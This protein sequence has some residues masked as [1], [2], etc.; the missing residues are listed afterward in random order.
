[1]INALQ[2]VII[3][4]VLWAICYMFGS[5]LD[6]KSE[7]NTGE[8]IVVGLIIIMALFQAVALPFMYYETS[9]SPLYMICIGFC[10]AVIVAYIVLFVKNKEWCNI[11]RKLLVLCHSASKK[12]IL[13]WGGLIALILFQVFYVIY[14]QHADE[15]DSYYIAQINTVLETNRLM[16]IEPTTGIDSFKQ[17]AT[18]KLIGHE[19]LLSL[20]A[21]FFHANA[22]FLCHMVMPIVMIPIHY[23]IVYELAKVIK[24]K[25][26]EIFFLLCLFVNAFSAFSG[27]TSSAFLF[28]RI[29]QGKAVLV[30]ILLPFMMLEFL[31]IY[32]ERNVSYKKLM[33]LIAVLWAGFFTTTVGLYLIPI[34]YFVYTA[35]YFFSFKDF[36]N[37]FKLCI[38]VLLSLPFVFVKFTTFLSQ[39]YFNGMDTYEV[40]VTYGSALFEKLLYND[41]G[42]IWVIFFVFSNIYIWK[43]GTQIE[44]MIST[45]ASIILFLTFANPLLM[46]IVVKYV[47]GESVYWR[48]FW[49]FQFRYIVVIAMIIYI[50]EEP[51]RKLMSTLVMLFLIAG[52][53]EYFFQDT[54]FHDRGNRYKISDRAVWISDEIIAENDDE[55]NY[56]LI[57]GYYSWEIRQYTGKVRLV[58]GRYAHHFYS[59]EDFAALEVLYHQLYESKAWNSNRLDEQLEYFHVNY[60]YLDKEAL[61]SNK[62]PEDFELVFEKDDYVL[63]KVN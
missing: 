2:L 59:E 57:P 41:K 63:Y 51:R 33:V 26:K 34:I 46:D 43:K 44:K 19:V 32:Q 35:A 62:L 12:K 13:I 52:S 8:R 18:Y 20:I 30:S 5:M 37:S 58:W 1:M 40:A 53:G 10:I 47:T 24:P 14:Y 39:D 17:L 61:E 25:Y 3:P 9:V 15:D 48:I 54:H 21:K 45:Y 11:K 60:V 55:N 4:P 38:P 56:L 42:W 28:Y 29:W 36:K 50:S 6:F 31:K 49:L 27:A 23:L 7:K 16:D 22:A